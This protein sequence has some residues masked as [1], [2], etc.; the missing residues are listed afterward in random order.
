M[1][2]ITV[3]TEKQF[4]VSK[5]KLQKDLNAL[6][7][8]HGIISEAEASVLIVS[9]ETMLEYVKTHL[10]ETGDEAKSHPV[11][12]FPQTEIE[13]PFLFPPD[14]ILHLGEIIVSY[15]HAKIEAESKKKTPESCVIELAEHGALHLMGIHHD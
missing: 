5:R 14:D 4:A 3:Q 1:I 12:S 13:G 15:D 2:T 10:K 6:F 11:L 8:K 9:A 7:K